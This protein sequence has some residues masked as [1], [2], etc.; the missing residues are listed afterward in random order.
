MLKNCGLLGK[1]ITATL[2][3]YMRWTLPLLVMIPIPVSLRKCLSFWQCSAK[4]PPEGAAEYR[5]MC[6]GFLVALGYA[7][8][9]FQKNRRV[10]L[11]PALLMALPLLALRAAIRAYRRYGP[12][13]KATHGF[14]ATRQI[15][16]QIVIYLKYPYL[17]FLSEHRDW[18]YR[19]YLYTGPMDKWFAS[20]VPNLGGLVTVINHYSQR[21]VV[22]PSKLGKEEERSRL[23]A[24]SLPTLEKIALFTPAGVEFELPYS[25]S[26]APVVS[27]FAKPTRGA[28][29]SGAMA[30]RYESIDR[31]IDQKDQVWSWS[32]VV[33]HLSRQTAPYLLQR[34]IVNHPEIRDLTGETLSCV[35]VLTYIDP[36][37]GKPAIFPA[38]WFKIPRVGAIVDNIHAASNR[39]AP[40][41]GAA[42][43]SCDGT[44]GPA[45]AAD[46]TWRAEHP[47]SGGQIEGRRIPDWDALT[48]LAC[49]AHVAFP[50]DLMVGWDIAPTPSGPVIVEGNRAPFCP[51]EFFR[52]EAFGRCVELEAVIELCL[53]ADG[54]SIERL[55]KLPGSVPNVEVA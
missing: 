18:Y 8:L 49:A 28:Q 45:M 7:R 44:L 33:E 16:E 30:W 25:R 22:G 1:C 47:D 38:S 26:N 53:L 11:V 9:D 40:G 5:A 39:D 27:L 20:S 51:E 15:L 23:Q 14:S 42:V 37:T 6:C 41:L 32:E 48:E 4:L 10:V 50:E 3:F 31:Y 34:R 55:V 12:G 35:R 43:D 19:K 52:N 46:L 21:H 29:G 54:P 36:A 2:V 17:L 24:N 13:V